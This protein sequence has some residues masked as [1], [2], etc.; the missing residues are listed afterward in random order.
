[1]TTT[2][3]KT[4][5]NYLGGRDHT[6]ILHGQEKIAMDVEKDESMRNTIDILTK[7]INTQ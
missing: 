2:P 1:M 6:T 7:K 3:L 5:G 4:I